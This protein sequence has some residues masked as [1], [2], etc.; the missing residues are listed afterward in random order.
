M[1]QIITNTGLVTYLNRNIPAYIKSTPYIQK[2]S[3]LLKDIISNAGLLSV[4]SLCDTDKKNRLLRFP[5]LANTSVQRDNLYHNLDRQDLG[6]SLMYVTPLSNVSGLT[7][8][9]PDSSHF[10]NA[11]DFANRLF[12][13]PLHVDVTEKDIGRISKILQRS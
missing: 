3:Y 12:T 2:I 8:R 5:V 4:S 6:A 7:D 9:F 10:P 11:T 1:R 13:L